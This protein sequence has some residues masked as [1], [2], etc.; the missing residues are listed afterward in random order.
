MINQKIKYTL[1]FLLCFVFICYKFL[2]PTLQMNGNNQKNILATIHSVTNGAKTIDII[3]ILDIGNDRFVAYLQ[4][5]TPSYIHF[6]KDNIGNY[7]FLNA[8]F[9]SNYE[10]DINNENKINSNLQDFALPIKYKNDKPLPLKIL[11]ITNHFNT[12]SKLSVRLVNATGSTEKV[13]I[14]VGK[15][16]A[17]I[18]TMYKATNAFSLE[19]RYFDEHGKQID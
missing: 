12:V 1:L 8:E 9:G 17:K 4:N 2:M 13:E 19:K 18:I 14:K 10:S 15:P 5:N 6:K 11:V 7:K 3:K 16:T